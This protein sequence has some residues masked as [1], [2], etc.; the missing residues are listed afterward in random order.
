MDAGL[1][2]QRFQDAVIRLANLFLSEYPGPVIN[3]FYVRLKEQ[4]Q[5]ELPELGN[6][7]QHW[8]DFSFVGDGEELDEECFCIDK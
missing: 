5:V 4:P 8:L 6:F 3:P 1:I 7:I 2:Y